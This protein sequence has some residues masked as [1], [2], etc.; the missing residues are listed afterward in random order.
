MDG[1]VWGRSAI[2]VVAG[3]SC[4]ASACRAPGEWARLVKENQSLREEKTRLERGA[5]ERDAT[6]EWLQKQIENLKGFAP[7][8]PADA[9]AAVKL[10]IASLSGGASYD[11]K[12]GDDGITVYLRPLDADG[13]VVKVPGRITIQLLDNS[14]LGSPR[15][16]GVCDFNDIKELRK[17]WYGKLGSQHYSLRC[18]F[19]AEAV[20]PES[21]KL[22]VSAAFVDFLTG[23]TLTANRE[24][25]F[26]VPAG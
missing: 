19:P 10:E 6:I 16:V 25:S 3:V 4:A 17:L 12:P 18:P 21:R 26:A 20:L 23:K 2:L 22:L 15:V 9:F 11:D 5:C 14:A 7:D 13:D 8:R 1:V 24:V